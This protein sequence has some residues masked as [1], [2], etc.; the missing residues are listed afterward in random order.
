MTTLKPQTIKRIVYFVIA[1]IFIILIL[2]FLFITPFPKRLLNHFN[3]DLIEQRNQLK[4]EKEQLI[5]NYKQDSIQN[6]YQRELQLIKTQEAQQKYNN[7]LHKLKFYEKALYDYRAGN[8]LP[9]FSTFTKN[10]TS[11]DTIPDRRFNTNN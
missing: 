2:L 1:G 5:E 10:L 6:A 8:Y 4:K 3:K 7:A 11:P 9:N